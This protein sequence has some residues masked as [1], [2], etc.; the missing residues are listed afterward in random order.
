MIW[1]P[2]HILSTPRKRPRVRCAA[3]TADGAVATTVT[4]TKSATAAHRRDEPQKRQEE[5]TFRLF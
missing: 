1:L 4:D 2:M 3:T 5:R